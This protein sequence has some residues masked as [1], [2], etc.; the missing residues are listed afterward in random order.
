MDFDP[1]GSAMRRAIQ[2][3]DRIRRAAEGYPDAGR[4]IQQ[5]LM[6]RQELHR[7]M[8]GRSEV[9][10]QIEERQDLIRQ[11]TERQDLY[12]RVEAGHMASLSDLFLRNRSP[13]DSFAYDTLY[14][15]GAS[16]IGL[17]YGLGS[18]GKS[19]K[20]LAET[21][22]ELSAAGG[23]EGEAQ[24]SPELQSMSTVEV[25]SSAEV[26]AELEIEPAHRDDKEKETEERQQ[27]RQLRQE[28]QTEAHQQLVPALE[29]LDPALVKMWDGGLMAISG[30]NPD[31]IRHFTVSLRELIG[32]ILRMLAPDDEIRKWSSDSDLYY[33]GKP[34]RR[35]RMRYICRSIDQPAFQEFVKVDY[36][37]LL[38]TIDL[39]HK[40]TH[41]IEAGFTRE[42]LNA[43]ETRTARS[44]LFLLQLGKQGG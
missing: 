36:K 11:L 34:T 41:V 9:I 30:T 2:D 15:S 42:Q 31:R 8:E 35:G 20:E 6:A 33:E 19:N 40:G 38:E 22:E 12:R 21:Y 1:V 23:S 43:L 27:R 16:A 26:V 25:F 44:L 37:V 17:A 18:F 29:A 32:Q 39:F 5:D 13:I 10:R 7:Q 3:M 4:Q 24:I 28:I 14:G